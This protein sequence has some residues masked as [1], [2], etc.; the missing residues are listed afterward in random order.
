M[1]PSPNVLPPATSVQSPSSNCPI[2]VEDR[3]GG[4]VQEAQLRVGDLQV[5]LDALGQ[6]GHDLAV[7]EVEDVDHDQHAQQ[8]AGVRAAGLDVAG[9]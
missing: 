7:E 1:A 5:G 9:T 2:W 6:D 8:V 4:A 3:E